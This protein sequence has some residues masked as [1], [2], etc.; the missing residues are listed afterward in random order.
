MKMPKLKMSSDKE[1][2]LARLRACSIFG[3]QAFVDAL[4]GDGGIH[5]ALDAQRRLIELLDG[6][7][8]PEGDR[9][10]LRWVRENGGLQRVSDHLAYGEEVAG[11]VGIALYGSEDRVPV[12]LTPNK[13]EEELR[14]RLMPEGMEW[15]LEVWP[16]WSIRV[17]KMLRKF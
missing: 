13:L 4:F 8:L 15:L 6:D 11:R 10:A 14:R 17:L 5:S 7:P 9:E 12:D 1:K 3:W 2:V 16:K